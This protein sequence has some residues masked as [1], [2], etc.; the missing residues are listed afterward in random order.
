[1][2]SGSYEHLYSQPSLVMAG[3]QQ[4]EEAR[5]RL[6][7]LYNFILCIKFHAKLYLSGSSLIL[8]INVD[9]NAG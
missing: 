4:G 5:D 7:R 8:V 2:P 1:M 9:I 6:L 3:C